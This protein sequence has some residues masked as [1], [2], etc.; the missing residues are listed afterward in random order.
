MGNSS[1][2][3]DKAKNE[4]AR[5]STK[6]DHKSERKVKSATPGR[7]EVLALYVGPFKVGAVL[8]EFLTES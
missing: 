1:E 3:H 8:L 5:K 2:K 6:I 7:P 4:S